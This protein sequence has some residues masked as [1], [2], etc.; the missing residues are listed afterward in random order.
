MFRICYTDHKDGKGSVTEHNGLSIFEQN[1]G[2]ITDTDKL[3]EY[4]YLVMAFLMGA[5]TTRYTNL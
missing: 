3:V 2:T 1:L 4:K 5:D